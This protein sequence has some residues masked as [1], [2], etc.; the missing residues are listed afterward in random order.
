MVTDDMTRVLQVGSPRQF[1]RRRRRARSHSIRSPSTATTSKRQGGSAANRRR[2]CRAAK[3]EAALLGDADARRRAAVAR[4]AARPH[5]DEH[6]RAVA[7]A[8][9]QVDLAAARA[10]AARDPI[11]ALA[12]ATSPCR[13][14]VG[15][16]SRSRLRRPAPW[17]CASRQVLH[18]RSWVPADRSLLVQAAAAAAGGQQYPAP[19]LYVVAT[20]IG[21]LA[22]LSLRALHVLA[23]RRRDRL[24]GHA[25]QRP[26]LRHFGLDQ[27]AARRARAQR[28]RGRRSRARPA[29]ARRARRL[30]QRRRHAGGE[31]PGRGAGR[32]GARRRLPGACRSRARA[33]R[34]PPC[35][36]PATPRAP[37]FTLRR[38]PAGARRRARRRRWRAA[39]RRGRPR[40][41]SR[42]R[43]ASRRSPRRSA[44]A[45]PQ[46]RLTRLPRAHQA[47]R[48]RGHAAAPRELPA[49]LAADANRARGEFVRRA[50][51]AGRRPRRGRRSSA[52]RAARAPAR[53]AAAQA[54][55]G[56]G[57]R[58]QRRAAQRALRARARAQGRGAVRG[59]AD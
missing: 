37:A 53:G 29:G 38:L 33:A 7:I 56:A 48:D 13:R 17:S 39:P 26:L 54:G 55:G 1:T 57:R 16:R 6:Q 24:R 32:R 47:V 43:I 50:A 4:V 21:N 3:H 18:R 58:D 15:E 22:D 10:R 46:R 45:C 40:C 42:R 19:A 11:I 9:D 59:G 36:W 34:S 28:A 2:K 41:C 14:Q 12:P 5:L 25:A 30:R 27:A 20:P 31:R 8:Q 51:R 49:W 35:R 52:R 23:T 44:E